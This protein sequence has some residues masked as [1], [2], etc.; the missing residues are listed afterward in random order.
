MPILEALFRCNPTVYCTPRLRCRTVVI[1]MLLHL[2][3]LACFE[4]APTV[5]IEI[6]RIQTDVAGGAHPFET[7]SAIFPARSLARIIA[8]SAIRRRRGSSIRKSTLTSASPAGSQWSQNRG[9]HAPRHVPRV[10]S[11]VYFRLREACTLRGDLL[12]PSGGSS[13]GG[14]EPHLLRVSSQCGSFVIR[15]PL[16]LSDHKIGCLAHKLLVRRIVGRPGSAP[17]SASCYFR[18]CCRGSGR[19]IR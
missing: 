11:S 17:L 4:G 1:S 7:D 14:L 12:S 16:Q 2:E 6:S 13:L 15:L 10:E 5:R 8:S 3:S 19:C 9:T 18:C